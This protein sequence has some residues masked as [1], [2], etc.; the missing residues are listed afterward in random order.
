MNTAP[1]IGTSVPRMEG[2]DKVTGQARYVDDIELPDMLFG[3]TVR[4]RIPRGRINKISFGAGINWE[5]FVIVSA[6]DMPGKNC[7]TLTD[8]DQPCL[9]DGVVNHPEEAI[10]LLAHPDRHLLPK[11]VEA[12]TVEY[13]PLPAI[14]S[15]EES[16]SRAQTIWGA[17]NIFK[18]YL[19][20]KGAVNSICQNAAHIFKGAYNT[21]AQEQL[22][23]G[24]NI[25]TDL[26]DAKKCIPHCV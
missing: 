23:I 7:I 14:F 10:L 8:D 26:S 2:R 3:A 12:V 22:Y 20:E 15:I 17:D 9:A 16:E 5:E 13:Q 6:K 19:I 21:D 24:N 1:I 18:S 11:A 4:S 25:R